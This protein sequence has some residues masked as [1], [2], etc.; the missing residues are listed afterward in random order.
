MG[1]YGRQVR[2]CREASFFPFPYRKGSPR[3]PK[4]D[5]G[6]TAHVLTMLVANAHTPPQGILHVQGLAARPR[7]TATIF[8]PTAPCPG[9]H[10]CQAV[11]IG[12][13]LG[14]GEE[15]TGGE[16]DVDTCAVCREL[17]HRFDLLVI[18]PYATIL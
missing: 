4:P 16:L 7:L 8:N 13:C 2:L 18:R 14:F 11:R 6:F 12:F 1:R 15:V 17:L 3:E 9:F 10:G 5:I